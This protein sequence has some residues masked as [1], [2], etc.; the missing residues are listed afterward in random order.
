[1]PG[2]ASL[3]PVAE[4]RL[5]RHI[6]RAGEGPL[7]S[8]D[9]PTLK[10]WK[11]KVID[12]LAAVQRGVPLAVFQRGGRHLADGHQVTRGEDIAAHLLQELMHPRAVGIEAAAIPVQ[13]RM[14][15]S[16]L[17]R[18]GI[19]HVEAQ[20]V[21]AAV[22]PEFADLFSS[23]RTA[24]FSSAEIRLLNGE[25][26]QII[27]PAVGVRT[28]VRCRQT[29]SASCSAG[30]SGSPSRHDSRT[31]RVGLF[32]FSDRRNHSCVRS[33]YGS[34]TISS[35]MRIPRAFAAPPARRQSRPSCRRMDRYGV[36]RHVVAA[37]HLRWRDRR[38]ASARWRLPS[39]FCR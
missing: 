11:L 4:Q 13:D 22:S 10:W 6:V 20:T 8:P 26:V 31:G 29:W 38:T 1:M 19:D 9:N 2:C 12:S 39:S 7:L 14:E 18:S 15:R 27:P 34:G 3:L 28:A 33:R 30:R 37:I 24:G 32:L 5:Q 16:G 36:V 23:A 17:L 21:D 35:T 25:Q